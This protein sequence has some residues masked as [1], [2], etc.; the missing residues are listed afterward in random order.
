MLKNVKW[1]NH[2]KPEI[3]KDSILIYY[4]NTDLNN[5]KS[6]I[7]ADFKC[8]F[9]KKETLSINELSHIYLT[10]ILSELLKREVTENDFVNNQYKKPYLQNDNIFFNI[11][12]S[13][14]A[15]VIAISNF[16]IGIDIEENYTELNIADCMNYAF[17]NEEINYCKTDRLE[18]F[19]IIWTLKEAYLKAIGI[20]LTDNLKE[21]N[22]LDSR[23]YKTQNMKQ[24]SFFSPNQEICSLVYNEN[25]N[26]LYFN[27][28]L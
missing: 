5:L 11:S 2:F 3:A 24:F 22:C 12:H 27:K 26:N 4:G 16:E 8:N 6:S 19:L 21:I 18:S 13:Q 14:N 20:G 25:A 1:E 17:S 28:I 7:N 15:F 9:A 23:I 10:K